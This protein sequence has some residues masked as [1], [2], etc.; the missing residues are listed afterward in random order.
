MRK[1]IFIKS[2]SIVGM[3]LLLGLAGFSGAICM[4]EKLGGSITVDYMAAGTYDLA[5][6]EVAPQFENITG[7]KV[8]I[9]AYPWA[10]LRE[11]NMMD[12]MTGT[13]TYDV[14]NGGYYLAKVFS[15]FVPLDDYIKQDAYG[16][17][18]IPGS[19]RKCD[20]Y[21]GHQIGIPYG[22]D[23]Y[24]IL[25][26]R[27]LFARTGLAIPQNWDEILI[28]AQKLNE[29]FKKDGINGYVF[30]AGAIE[31]L[32]TLLFP[33]YSG[34]LIT[35][36]NKFHLDETEA[37]KAFE[38]IKEILKYAPSDVLGLSIDEANAVF[39]NG[40]AGMIECWPSFVRAA[41]YDPERSRIVGKWGIFPYPKVGFPWL[42]MWQ[43]YLS[44]YSKNQKAGWEWMKFYTSE[45]FAKH[46]FV[47][48]GI[49]SMYPATYRDPELLEIHKYEFPGLLAN[50]E[51]AKNPSL[52]GEAQDFLAG[53]IGEMLM[54]K[55]TPEQAVSK[56]NARWA[57]LEVPEA[58]T[59]M[60]E[61]TGLKAK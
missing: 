38:T 61:R 56:V 48:Y 16:V 54:G 30:S 52:S 51:R 40:K 11:K 19:L 5:A 25:Y 39:L 50:F 34:T 45:K 33:K 58:I 1:K 6:K 9:I 26:R 17:N 20:Y 60:G 35:A 57:T 24:S 22:I 55:V 27:D 23:A 36:D 41:A 43:M 29:M 13:G 14:V 37:V 47:K 7:A 59:E 28:A 21:R 18:M 46:F 8:K 42:S 49:G 12:L 31:Q 2:I 32:P 53:M 3:V 15:H 10:V 4:A 44:E